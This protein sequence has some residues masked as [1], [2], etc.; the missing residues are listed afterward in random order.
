M[1]RRTVLFLMV[2]WN[3]VLASNAMHFARPEE[4]WLSQRR[5]SS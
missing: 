4:A 3:G 2:Q 1:L 5:G